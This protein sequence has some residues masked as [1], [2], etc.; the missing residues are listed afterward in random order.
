MSGQLLVKSRG[1]FGVESVMLLQQQLDKDEVILGWN[2]LVK[3]ASW[4]GLVSSV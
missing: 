1:F 4:N 3:K 2:Y